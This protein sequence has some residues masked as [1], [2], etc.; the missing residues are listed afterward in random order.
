MGGIGEKDTMGAIGHSVAPRAGAHMGT[1]VW[2]CGNVVG[3]E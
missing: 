1:L 2:L 3:E